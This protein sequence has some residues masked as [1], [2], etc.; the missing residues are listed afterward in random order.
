MMK[1]VVLVVKGGIGVTSRVMVR[2]NEKRGNY[3]IKRQSQREIIASTRK[4]RKGGL[5]Y[6]EGRGASLM[7]VWFWGEGKRTV[8]VASCRRS[9]KVVR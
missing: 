4:R 9:R 8:E 3:E 1:D 2:V 6:A 5:F 7:E